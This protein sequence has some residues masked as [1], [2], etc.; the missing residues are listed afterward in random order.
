MWELDHKESWVLKNSCFWTVVLEKTLESPLDCKEIQPVNPKG[1]QSWIFI[2][3]TD[4]EAEALILVWPTKSQTQLS[5]WTGWLAVWL[6]VTP[7][8]AVCQASHLSLSPGVCSSS[9][10]LSW[11]CY[12]TTSSCSPFSSCPRSFPASGSFPVSHLFTSGSQ[13]IGAS[14]S[15]LPMNIQGWFPIGLTDLISF[16]S[17]VLSRDFSSTKIWKHLFFSTQLSLWSNFHVYTRLLFV[18]LHLT[19]S[20]H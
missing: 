3:R 7:W 15:V 14:A 11:W 8:T 18:L 13:S 19:I 2:G 1:N 20:I 10:S 16:Q 4:A 5:D 9:C 12:L 6:F 17:K